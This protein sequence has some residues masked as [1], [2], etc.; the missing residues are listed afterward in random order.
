MSHVEASLRSYN[1]CHPWPEDV[2]R[3]NIGNIADQHFAPTKM[4]VEAMI[5]ENIPD[6][7]ITITGNT[8]IDALL[9]TVEKRQ[10]SSIKRRPRKYS[11]KKSS[12]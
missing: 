2:N 7:Q 8:V 12:E 9:S 11:D 10:K 1:I 5:K 3:K 6:Q 4:S